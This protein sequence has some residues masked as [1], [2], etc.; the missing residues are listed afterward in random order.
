VK[1]VFQYADAY[2]KPVC[3]QGLPV[4]LSIFGTHSVFIC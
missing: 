1:S 3:Q 2:F 4:N